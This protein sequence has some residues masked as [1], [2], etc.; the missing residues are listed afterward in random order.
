MK[1]THGTSR[2]TPTRV[3]TANPRVRPD[4]SPEFPRCVPPLQTIPDRD[5]QS[6]FLPWSVLPLDSVCL[7]QQRGRNSKPARYVRSFMT[8][9]ARDGVYPQLHNPFVHPVAS[10]APPLLLSFRH[11]SLLILP[12]TKPNSESGVT[13]LPSQSDPLTRSK[14]PS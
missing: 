14:S 3:C 12:T 9:P 11:Q 10:N 6:S 7:G 4:A 13:H 2:A 5:S 1:P 8:Q